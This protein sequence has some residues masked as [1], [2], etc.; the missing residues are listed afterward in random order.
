MTLF[1]II[2]F[3]VLCVTQ[4]TNQPVLVDRQMSLLKQSIPT[5]DSYNV[6]SDYICLTENVEISIPVLFHLAHIFNS[7]SKCF[8]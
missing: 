8:T 6:A 5:R 3:D 4:T 2:R 1:T 7:G